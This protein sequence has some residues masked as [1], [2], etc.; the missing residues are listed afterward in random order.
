[1]YLDN[2]KGIDNIYLKSRV[3]ITYGEGAFYFDLNS[4]KP[5]ITFLQGYR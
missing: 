4:Q 3:I 2:L 5:T 1:M